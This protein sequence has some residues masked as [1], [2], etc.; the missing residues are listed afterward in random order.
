MSTFFQ[1]IFL[2]VIVIG[3]AVL[4]WLNLKKGGKDSMQDDKLKDVK[5]EIFKIKDEM[6]G[7][8]EKNLEFIFQM[9]YESRMDRVDIWINSWFIENTS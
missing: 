8:L 3:L 4:I 2:A 7:S 5:D 6:K 9:A 1:I